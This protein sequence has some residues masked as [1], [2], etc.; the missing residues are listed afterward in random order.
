MRF[1][2]SHVVA[3]K[4]ESGM[5]APLYFAAKHEDHLALRKQLD[6]ALGELKSDIFYRLDSVESH[7]V[8]GEHNP[9]NRG[10]PIERVAVFWV[11]RPVPA[12]R[13]QREEVGRST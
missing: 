3:L 4:L 1:L 9:V 11:D 13:L 5:S 7:L 6:M 2:G 10:L 12:G 8:F